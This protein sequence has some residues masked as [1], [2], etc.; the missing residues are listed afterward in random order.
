MAVL[1]KLFGHAMPRTGWFGDGLY[2]DIRGGAIDGVRRTHFE[3]RH[4]CPRCGQ[5][6]IAAVAAFT[7][8]RK[9]YSVT[10]GEI[11]HD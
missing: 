6:W 5:R 3:I 4:K 11:Y 1:C 10:K 2:G 9:V 8:G 7:E